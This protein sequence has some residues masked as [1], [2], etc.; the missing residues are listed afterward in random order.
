MK[1]GTLH[2]ENAYPDGEM[3][4]ERYF[5]Q[6]NCSSIHC[7]PLWGDVYP[8]DVNVD[9]VLSLETAQRILGGIRSHFR[10]GT[11]LR[12]VKRTCTVETEVVE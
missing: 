12:I 2:W 10:K 1:V 8:L 4:V 3:V 9:G 7:P 11:Q 5:L 6:R